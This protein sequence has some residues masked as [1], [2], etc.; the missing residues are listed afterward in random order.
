MWVWNW[1]LP[2]SVEWCDEN[3]KSSVVKEIDGSYIG[4]CGGEGWR[5]GCAGEGRDYL[6]E[7]LLQ[8]TVH[9]GLSDLHWPNLVGDVA[10]LYKNH[11]QLR[12][13]NA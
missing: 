9:P 8:Q 4:K 13:G 6:H 11:L 2:D 3:V 5:D 7:V 1:F 10:A 12:R